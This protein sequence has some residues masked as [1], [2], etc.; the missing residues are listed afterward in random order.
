MA[1]FG[2]GVSASSGFADGEFT[3]GPTLEV[4]VSE[5]LNVGYGNSSYAVYE[6]LNTAAN[7]LEVGTSA[8]PALFSVGYKTGNSPTDVEGI[9]EPT[10]GYVDMYLR[11]LDAGRSE[12]GGR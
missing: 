3:Q 1:T 4:R 7:P 8:D 11:R 10:S 12:K 9:F 5:A 2:V 6:L